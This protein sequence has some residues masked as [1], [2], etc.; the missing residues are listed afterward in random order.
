MKSSPSI[1]QYVVSVKLPMKISSI[2]V[3][4]LEKINFNPLCP[5]FYKHVIYLFFPALLSISIFSNRTF[6]NLEHNKK[7]ILSTYPLT[8]RPIF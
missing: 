6:R 5:N 7:S 4:L 1:W 3:A 8:H 2:F